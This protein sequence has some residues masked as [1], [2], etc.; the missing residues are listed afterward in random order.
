VSTVLVSWDGQIRGA[1]AVTDTVKP[2]AAAV[3]AELRRL[4]LRPVMLT[5]DNQAT[6]R[7]VAAATG[8]NRVISE[9]LPGAKAEVVADLQA[10]GRSVAMAGDGVN[11]GPAL[12]TARLAWRSARA[13]MWRSAP[14]T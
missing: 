2:S 7:A 1:L 6:A 5:G 9:T 10:A 11:D 13:P 14:R 8:I 4:G 12:A 3:I